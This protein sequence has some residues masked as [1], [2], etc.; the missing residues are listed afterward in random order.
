M[1]IRSGFVSNSSSSSFLI[2][3][4]KLDIYQIQM[5]KDHFQL[6]EKF[7]MY[8][9]DSWN[10]WSITEGDEYI[11]GYTSMDNFNM[12]EFLT[13]I[14]KVDKDDIKWSEYGF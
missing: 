7:G 9:G 1:K 12:Y 3:K 5:I 14:V 11:T 6:G 10:E 4:S 8:C 13:Q 2:L